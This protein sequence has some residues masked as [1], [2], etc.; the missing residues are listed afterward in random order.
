MWVV[1]SDRVLEVSYRL[2]RWNGGVEQ[3]KTVREEWDGSGEARE[4]NESKAGQEE[5]KRLKREGRREDRKDIYI[6]RVK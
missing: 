4:V 6:Y 1:G 5:R 3:P 2:D